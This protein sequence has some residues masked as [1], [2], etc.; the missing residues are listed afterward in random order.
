MSTRMPIATFVGGVS[1]QPPVQRKDT[2]STEITNSLMPVYSGVVKR[3]GTE[4][5][6]APLRTYGD[7]NITS[8][9]SDTMFFH[10][11][12]R[13][14]T[15]RYLVI[16]DD[17]R[18]SNLIEVFGLDGAKYAVT[19]V[20]KDTNDPK[21]YITSGTGDSVEKLKAVSIAD[22]TFL[23]NTEKVTALTGTATGYTLETG[24]G[25][26]NGA[27]WEDLDQPYASDSK[28]FYLASDYGSYPAGF[29]K[30]QN[31]A[32][33]TL[34]FYVRVPTDLDDSLV[35]YETMPVKLTF[36]G[37]DFDLE[38]VDWNPRLSGDDLTNPGPS[39]IGLALSD[40][41]F[42]RSRL[43]FAAEEQLVSS[44][45]GD[46]YNLWVDNFANVVDS[47]PIDQQLSGRSVNNITYLIPFAKALVIFT[48]GSQQYEMRSDGYLTPS[49]VNLVPTTSYRSDNIEPVALGSQLYFSSIH[50]LSSNIWEY[51][52]EPDSINNVCTLISGHVPGYIPPA[53]KE[54]R[55]SPN[56]DLLFV[57]TEDEPNVIYVYQMYWS[58]T[59][60]VQDAW[61]KWIFD[62]D[63]EILTFN[64]FENTMYLLIRYPNGKIYL[65]KISIIEPVVESGMPY[66]PRMDRRESVVGVYSSTTKTT[67][68]T[69][70][71]K[72]DTIDEVVTG[73]GWGD[74]A[75]IRLPV[76]ENDSSGS[77]TVI[78]VNGKK[79]TAACWVGR[80]YEQSITLS[81][82]VV[83][84]NN[85]I[86]VEGT[87]Q[88]R[89]LTVHH[90]DT[91][92]YTIDITPQGRPT[93]SR[94]YVPSLMGSSSAVF[95][96][97][98]IEE[99]GKFYTK[100]LA[101]NQGTEIKI[102]NDTPLPSTFVGAEYI[103]TF[104]PM[105]RNIA[106]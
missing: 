3:P 62:E 45:A 18:A 92:T 41:A 96:Q 52:Y 26:D 5:I 48:Q 37:T 64:I 54:I 72:D 66:A 25:L 104:V 7:L 53:V 98:L 94:T 46:L 21:D 42:H 27:T 99:Y 80:N 75:G 33:T 59:D 2:Q 12:D 85:N 6:E 95:G 69:L 15:H 10:W 106:K 58:G 91:G 36:D 89:A 47:D 102:K 63:C 31:S 24:F 43:W 13:D 14:P 57:L 28:Y 105:R 68:F 79:D 4:F 23:L 84:D 88:V 16:I 67:Q 60:K 82:V 100:V 93:H 74:L 87:I 39:F 65:E 1:R 55:G 70:T 103:I 50:S 61:S 40:I 86:A 44:Q 56:N 29:Y 9:T 73:P 34:P 19:S 35:D 49:T 20:L 51:Y 81:P 17:A 11:I 32:T 71:Y 38:F 8:P 83:R 97:V 30:S 90:K 78:S 22:S 77:T 76:T 101:S